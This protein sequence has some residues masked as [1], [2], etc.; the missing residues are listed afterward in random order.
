MIPLLLALPAGPLLAWKRG[1]LMGVMQRLFF[2][3]LLAVGA[4]LL[5]FALAHDRFSLAPFGIALGVWVMAGAVTEWL[6]RV[7]A[8]S[9]GAEEVVRRARNLPRSAY[10]TL[11]AHFGVG[12]MVV[13][14]VGTTAYREEHVLLMKPGDKLQ[15]AGY[16]VAFMGARQGRGPNYRE[17]LA[18]FSVAR[19]GAPVT[20]LVPSKRI[21]DMPPQPTTEAGIHNSW[22]GDLYIV[23]GDEQ[24]KDGAYAVRVYFNPLVRCIWIG[25]LIMFIG[26]GISLA[27]RRLRLGVPV[28][29]GKQ[30][31]VTA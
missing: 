5:T 22:R 23:I 18:T 1:D 8:G 16:E 2:A 13:G 28:K 24:L 12:M 14:V 21:Y 31:A 27:D 15:A 6:L 25:A 9:A 26:G 4:A 3:A 11:L 29:A 17:E 19:D 10:G 30:K 7:K 20:E